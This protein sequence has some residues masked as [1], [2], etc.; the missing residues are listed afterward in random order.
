MKLDGREE[1]RVEHLKL[2]GRRD[3]TF[4]EKAGGRDLGVV[5]V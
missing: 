1:V 3:G 2:Q 5:G 4:L